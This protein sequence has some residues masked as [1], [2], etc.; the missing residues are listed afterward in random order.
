M[1]PEWA[2]LTNNPFSPSAWAKQIAW[3]D[4]ITLVPKASVLVAHSD[5]PLLVTVEQPIRPGPGGVWAIAAV[6]VAPPF[7]DR[8]AAVLAAV[9]ARLRPG[10]LATEGARVLLADIAG[11]DQYGATGERMLQF[12]DLLAESAGLFSG[13]AADQADLVGDGAGAL[14][15]LRQ[16]LEKHGDVDASRARGPIERF[17]VAY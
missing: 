5:R 9:D 16:V 11:E 2:Q 4:P 15:G 14:L 1:H 17:A 3:V 6:K 7:L 12:A 10:V 8:E 13:I